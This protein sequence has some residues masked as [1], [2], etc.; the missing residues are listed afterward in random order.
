MQ[1]R[2]PYFS[3][4]E[5]V[6]VFRQL[7][8]LQFTLTQAKTTLRRFKFKTAFQNENDLQPDEYFNSVWEII[9]VHT[10]VY[11]MTIH[12]HCACACRD[13]QLILFVFF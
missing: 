12:V 7:R 9:S 8:S 4:N 5:C 10:N 6:D 13:K 2:W 11:H 1:V 3:L